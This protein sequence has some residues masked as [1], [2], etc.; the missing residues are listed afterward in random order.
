MFRVLR[1]RAPVFE[2]IICVGVR[3]LFIDL[4]KPEGTSSFQVGILLINEY[5]ARGNEEGEYKTVQK[6]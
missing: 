1:N 4:E 5:V 3:R 6:S 2:P